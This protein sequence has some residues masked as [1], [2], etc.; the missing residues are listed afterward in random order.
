MITYQDL[1]SDLPPG[2]VVT[3]RPDL[4]KLLV[5]GPGADGKDWQAALDAAMPLEDALMTVWKLQLQSEYRVK[6][7]RER[8]DHN[9]EVRQLVEARTAR[10]A[11]LKNEMDATI[12]DKRVEIAAQV[13]AKTPK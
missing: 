11:E 1:E 8:E 6:V 10:F 13:K 3:P 2:A 9:R 5:R 4:G 7:N 12:E